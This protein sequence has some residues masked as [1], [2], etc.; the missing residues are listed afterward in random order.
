MKALLVVNS[1]ASSVTARNTVMVHRALARD[2]EV[3]LV[4]TNRRGH[5]T[6]YAHDA[7]RRGLDAVIGFGGDGT[8]NEVATGIAGTS[9][10]LG[11]IPGGSTNVFA[12]TI[13]L[14]NDPV[15]AA[16]LIADGMST[17]N[18]RPIGLGRANGRYFCFH[19]GIGFDAAVVRTVERRAAMKRWLG[20][21]LFVS[22]AL[23]TWFRYRAPRFRIEAG[24]LVG[25]LAG[26]TP[27]DG[28]LDGAFSVI[29]NSNPYTF[30]GNRPLNLS[31]DATLERGLVAL[32]FTELTAR[33]VIGAAIGALRSEVGTTPRLHRWTDLGSVTIRSAAPVP[34]QVDGDYLGESTALD[35]EHVPDAVGLLMPGRASTV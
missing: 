23:S 32:T 29:L 6:R 10:A 7:A 12:R 28:H 3:A 5:A 24:P 2:H 13:G 20:H 31:L 22:A 16:P 35:I 19:I 25:E 15:E 14:P 11:V 30:L 21:P 1:F 17:A 18:I 4:E 34:Y 33:G 9:T 27:S 26:A 8:L